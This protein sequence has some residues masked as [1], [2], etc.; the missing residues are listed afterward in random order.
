M[1]EIRM[2]KTG[3]VTLNLGLHPNRAARYECH[4]ERILELK[5]REAAALKAATS[6]EGG[7]IRV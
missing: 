3:L 2:S 5:R 1:Y 6:L 7:P 4:A